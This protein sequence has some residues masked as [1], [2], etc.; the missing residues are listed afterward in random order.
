MTEQF[1]QHG[2]E[3][4]IL[5]YIPDALTR[6]GKY[7]DIGG[8]AATENSN[9]FFLYKAGWEGLVVEPY[10][11]F[12]LEHKSV[13]PNDV[14][15]Q[16]AITNYIGK[17]EHLDTATLGSPIGDIYMSKE[18]LGTK[19][20]PLRAYAG[21]GAAPYDHFFIDCTTMDQLIKDYPN[22]TEPDFISIDIDTNEDKLFACCDFTKFKPKFLLVEY[23]VRN[24]DYR[25]VWG[26]LLAPFYDEKE[27]IG[28]NAMYQRKDA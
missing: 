9:T 25:K 7:I 27:L 16:K 18:N 6:K 23:T 2:E 22:F 15:V 11:R 12:Y 4:L 21:A 26:H 17:S 20:K 14:C 1:S 10:E 13:R 24:V 3:E 19:E 28:G 8:G 5:K